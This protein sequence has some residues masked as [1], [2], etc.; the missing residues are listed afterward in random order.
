MKRFLISF[1]ALMLLVTACFTEAPDI[2]FSGG[3]LPI[4]TLDKEGAPKTFSFK[5]TAEW[6]AQ[7][8]DSWCIVS[9]A[10]GAAGDV[11][12]TVRAESNPVL[13]DRS[14]RIRVQSGNLYRDITVTQDKK[15]EIKPLSTS[16]EVDA[17]EGDFFME[18]STNVPVSARVT[19]GDAWI[20]YVG[21]KALETHRLQFHVLANPDYE[22]RSGEVELINQET[23]ERMSSFTVSQKALELFQLSASETTVAS[24]GGKF[25]VTVRSSMGYSISSMPD[26]VKQLSVKSVTKKTH[27]FEVEANTTP[28]DRSGIIV[29]CNESGTCVPFTVNQVGEKWP[30]WSKLF[31]HKSL[32]MVF[33]ATWC[34]YCPRTGQAVSLAQASRP[35]RFE[36]VSIHCDGS[37]LQFD[38]YTPLLEEYHI[39]GYPTA[40]VDGRRYVKGNTP[41]DESGSI[42]QSQDETESHYSA[43]TAIGISSAWD[44][45]TLNVDVDL[46]CKV[47]E[48]HKVTVFLVEDGIVG[49]QADYYDGDHS[50]Y[51]HDAVARKALTSVY[52]NP[53][54]TDAKN[55]IKSFSYS[56]TVS[57]DYVK[58]NLRVL[59]Y[60][61]RQFGSQERLSDF[62]SEE[63]YVENAASVAAGKTLKPAVK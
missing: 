41:A 18:V 44:G 60:V 31:V 16:V 49:S 21:V 7:A 50:D 62:S 14:T 17:E 30:N 42:T 51:V 59:V 35:G 25:T 48:S 63:Y 2:I 40:V 19:K 38:Q 4:V 34:G 12:V 36:P 22:A 27:T 9:P 52:G 5:A 45:N 8:S 28:T 3:S 54:Q 57:S 23:G 47:A 43:S 61:Q 46:Y 10:S 56:T 39:T 58:D 24:K 20:S 13:S 29:F 37:D 6:T 55:T 33:T 15:I 11:T 26:W 53:F 32:I 1:T